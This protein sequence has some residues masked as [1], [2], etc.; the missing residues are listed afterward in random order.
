MGGAEPIEAITPEPA[1]IWLRADVHKAGERLAPLVCFAHGCLFMAVVGP[2]RAHLRVTGHLVGEGAGCDVLM[3]T[4]T[5]ALSGIGT[6]LWH[7][8]FC[9]PYGAMV[10]DGIVRTAALQAAI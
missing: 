4:A 6:L 10:V 7:G 2:T 1:A 8:C 5:V 3:C 9:N